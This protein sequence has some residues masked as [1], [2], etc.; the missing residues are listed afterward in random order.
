MKEFIQT[1]AEVQKSCS[2]P[3][4]NAQRTLCLLKSVLGKNVS[5]PPDYSN[6]RPTTWFSRIL[7]FRCTMSFCYQFVK[8]TALEFVKKCVF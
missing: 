2:G 4:S 7:A 3:N 5:H 6:P 1:N 8:K